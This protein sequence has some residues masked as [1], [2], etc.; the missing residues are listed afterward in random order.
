MLR[1]SVF[2]M[3]MM[4]MAASVSAQGA[5]VSGTVGWTFSDGVSGNAVMVPGVGTFDRIDPKDS[6]AWGVRLGLFAGAN[7]EIGFLY[8]QQPTELELGGTTTV[9]IG[10][11]KVHNY[12]GYYA[13]NFGSAEA[14][15]RPYLLFGLGATPVRHG[16]RHRDERAA[17]HSRRNA[18]LV[19]RCGRRENLS[20]EGR[21]GSASRGDG[22]RPTSSRTPPAGG[23]I[24]SG[25]ATS[26]ATHSMR[27][28]SSWPPGSAFDS[29]GAI[30]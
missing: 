22:P 4:V 23:A 29:S 26:W 9:K 8:D 16:Q 20:G 15:V 10:D 3:T 19:D 2:L 30:E 5:E 1:T 13:F 28:S 24:R 25:A 12:Q 14:G 27:I 11:I 17:R 18:I 6:W 7:S 21:S